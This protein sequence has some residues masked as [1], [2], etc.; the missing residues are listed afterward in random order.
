MRVYQQLIVF[1][2]LLQVSD[3]CHFVWSN[4]EILFVLV[5]RHFMLGSN[6][7]RWRIMASSVSLLE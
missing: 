6:A 5:I 4:Q 2:L 3:Q 1:T 7:I